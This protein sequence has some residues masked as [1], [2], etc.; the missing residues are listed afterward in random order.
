MQKDENFKCTAIQFKENKARMS[1]K[2]STSCSK[3]IPLPLV[4]GY[5]MR[6]FKKLNKFLTKERKIHGILNM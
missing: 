1:T 4:N 5:A 6:K 3:F 2:K